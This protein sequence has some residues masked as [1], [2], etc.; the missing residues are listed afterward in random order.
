MYLQVISL[1]GVVRR[2]LQPGAAGTMAMAS[3]TLPE[4][5][6]RVWI[7]D[8]AFRGDNTQVCKFLSLES[9]PPEDNLL[10]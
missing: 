3:T 1:V 2:R 9:Y 4:S 8:T 6:R 5:A 7:G 10:K